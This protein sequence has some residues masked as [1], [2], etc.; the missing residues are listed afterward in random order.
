MQ[1][2]YTNLKFRPTI[3]ENRNL[4]EVVRKRGKV[5][6]Y[7]CIFPPLNFK[8]VRMLA[9]RMGFCSKIYALRVERGMVGF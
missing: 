3:S 1:K 4:R 2:K 5:P 6:P 8:I 9:S 7:L